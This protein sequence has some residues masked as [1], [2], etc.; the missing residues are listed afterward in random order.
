MSRKE[1]DR[2]NALR[3]LVQKRVPCRFLSFE[4]AEAVSGEEAARRLELPPDRVFKTLV[5]VGRS[6]G[7]YVFVIPVL[8]ELDLRRAAACVGETKLEMLPQRELL[9][10]T[11]YVHGGCSPIGMKKTFPTVLD[12][13][14]EGKESIVFSA[15]RIGCHVEVSPGELRRALDYTLAEVCAEA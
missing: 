6:G 9:P 1:G 5:T 7:H 3:I 10:L 4:T 13:S 14:A 12:A 8:R 15:G 11:G 2:T